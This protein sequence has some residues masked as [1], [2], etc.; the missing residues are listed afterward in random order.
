[1]DAATRMAKE[2]TFQM[3]AQR[4]SPLGILGGAFN[5]IRQLLEGTKNCIDGRS[6]GGR[7]VAGNPARCEEF[8][9]SAP[10][11][12]V[13]VHHVKTSRSMDMHVNQPWS[14]DAVIEVEEFGSG[15]NLVIGARK[16]GY[17]HP[18]LDHHQGLINLF[19]RCVERA[20]RQS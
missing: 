12:G 11:L 18:V 6:N 20:R 5:P 19:K 17:H 8:L 2:G 9:H 1:M 13:G 3:Y 10:P 4:L 16:D 15:W 14:Q 7:K